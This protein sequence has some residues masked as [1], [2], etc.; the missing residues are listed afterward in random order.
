MRNQGRDEAHVAMSK[1]DENQP[2][3]APQAYQGAASERDPALRQALLVT[4]FASWPVV[5]A[6]NVINASLVAAVFVNDVP[7]PLLLA[8]YLSMLAMV[9]VRLV[10]WRQF[11]RHT[12]GDDGRRWRR[13]AVIGSA[14]SGLLWGA[15]GAMFSLRAGESG[16]MV[17]GFV[18][19]GMGAGTVASL[20]PVMPAFYAYLLPSILPFTASLLAAGNPPQLVM[21]A[22]C[23]V[24]LVG[25]VLLG[26]RT[27]RWLVQSLALRSENA[28]LVRSLEARVGQ[29]TVQLEAINARLFRDI[30]V[31]RRAES[32][33]E[34]YAKRQS[35][36]AAFGQKALS[37]IDLDALFLEALAL[38]RKGLNVPRAAILDHPSNGRG[39]TVRLA[40]D[41]ADSSSSGDQLPEGY[42]SPA[43]YALMTRRPVISPDLAQE[44]RFNVPPALLDGGVA[45]VVDVVILGGKRPLGVLEAS[46]QRIRNFALADVSYLE[47]IAN[48]L[49]AAIDRKTT[50]HDIQ[51]LA[52]R[53]PLTGLPN[54]ALFRDQLMQAVARTQR[55]GE[56]L[57]VLLL[58]LDRFKDVNDSLGHSA[59]DRLL[60]DVACR[61]RACVRQS[62]PP[63]RLGG[64]EFA[65]ILADLKGQEA[66]SV[67]AS[68]AQK[69]T[70]R[71]TE[72]FLLDGQDI[73]IGVTIGITLCPGD[74]HLVDEL[75]R[76][77]DLALYRAKIDHRGSYRFYSVE[78]SARVELRKALEAD[79]RRALIRQEFELYY[80]PQI[81]L[82]DRRIVGAEAL[83]RWRHPGRGLLHPGEFLDVA[84]SGGL[85]GRL[86]GWVLEHACGDAIAYQRLLQSPFS[87]AINVSPSE[88]RGD[89]LVRTLEQLAQRLSCD[90]GWLEIEVTE[91][92]FLPSESTSSGLHSLARLRDLGVSV[93]ID[94]FGTG[95]SNL[96][97]LHALPVDRLKI[98]ST[99]IANLGHDREAEAIVRAI[100]ALAHNLGLGVV[101]EGVETAA[102]L[103]FLRAEACD[104]A[105]GFRFSPPRP[106]A[107]FIRF[108]GDYAAG[109]SGA[110]HLAGGDAAL[111]N[112]SR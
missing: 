12:D 50:E 73:H 35:A 72:A 93:S 16:Q 6:A 96:A 5:L 40:L 66:A 28:D 64:D 69:I 58:D 78:M 111:S 49:A 25:I 21:A 57:A 85:L 81:D 51:Q 104:R 52:L 8:W 112:I 109:E 27:N 105:Q 102:Q 34:Q 77:A 38:V 86:G 44:T 14:T 60:I 53:D 47:A 91:Q 55:S 76:N 13:V 2:T 106:F 7:Q 71:L 11:Q 68:V 46:D 41:G 87:V 84:E 65:I 31:R 80:Q 97:S 103:E 108:L 88:F 90:F 39:F 17:M 37:G 67:A 18:L 56:T 100:I 20:T 15:A 22:A 48:M 54:R 95:Y 92:M 63:A 43:G 74:G 10:L 99:F 107:D 24:Y 59:G 70:D 4:A 75:M 33:L 19:G 29:R 79:L 110:D 45:S 26:Q 42:D 83:L 89:E 82:A 101:A 1:A 98:D 62:E 3:P 61:L 30:A 32:A 23:A 9:A 36:I 94:D